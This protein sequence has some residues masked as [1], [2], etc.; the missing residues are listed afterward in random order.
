MFGVQNQKNDRSEK[1]LSPLF[2]V[3]S[4]LDL[5]NLGRNDDDC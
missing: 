5:N 3:N 4:N 2:I 1:R